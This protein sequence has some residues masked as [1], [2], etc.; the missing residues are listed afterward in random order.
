MQSV[1]HEQARKD[2]NKCA[3]LAWRLTFS[4][5][6]ARFHLIIREGMILTRQG[7]FLVL[8]ILSAVL[9]GPAVK[10]LEAG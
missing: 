8:V 3:D 10:R 9:L 6:D 5:V 7:K 1:C 4:A 2:N